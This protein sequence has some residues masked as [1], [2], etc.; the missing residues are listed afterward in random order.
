MI[1][2]KYVIYAICGGYFDN[3]TNSATRNKSRKTR[4]IHTAKFKGVSSNIGYSKL[5]VVNLCHAG[6]TGNIYPV[7]V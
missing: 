7:A 6:H 3:S 1:D 4:T 2:F 5:P